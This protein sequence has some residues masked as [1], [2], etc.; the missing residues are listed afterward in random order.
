M[1][2]TVH[3]HIQ[4]KTLVNSVSGKINVQPTNEIAS[5]EHKNIDKCWL[6]CQN[7]VSV[8][9]LKRLRIIAKSPASQQATKVVFPDSKV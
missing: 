6:N 3:Q 8:I 7:A 2:M 5:Q 4:Y 9:S 1:S